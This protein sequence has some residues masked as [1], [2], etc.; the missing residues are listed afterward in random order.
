MVLLITLLVTPISAYIDLI[1]LLFTFMGASHFMFSVL[2][3]VWNL[4]R[5]LENPGF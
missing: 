1:L 5:K 3:I 2:E 4:H